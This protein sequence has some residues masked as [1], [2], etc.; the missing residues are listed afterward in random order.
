M[1]PARRKNWS[2]GSPSNKFC[3]VNSPF[4]STLNRAR[5]TAPRKEKTVQHIPIAHPVFHITA[6]WLILTGILLL[7]K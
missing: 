1:P 2:G 7:A 4:T 6:I 3:L 5:E